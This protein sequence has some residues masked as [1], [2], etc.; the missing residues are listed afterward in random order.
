MTEGTK[1]TRNRAPWRDDFEG[2]MD[3]LG[4]ALGGVCKYYSDDK[5]IIFRG[6]Q[7]LETLAEGIPD[8][9][10]AYW[11]MIGRAAGEARD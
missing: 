7:G 9:H 8:K 2:A 11:W 3:R 10:A 4:N 1:R 5:E 6:E